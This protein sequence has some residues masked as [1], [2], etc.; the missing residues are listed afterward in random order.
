MRYGCSVSAVTIESGLPRTPVRL[1]EIRD[2]AVPMIATHGVR[3]LTHRGVDRA[4]HV[5]LG[6]TSHY[7]PTRNAL[8][9]LV[10]DELIV[11][12]ARSARALRRDIAGAGSVDELA[13]AVVQV[14]DRLGSFEDDL[15]ARY[16]LLSDAESGSLRL[17]L[18]T[19]SATRADSIAA[20]ESV[21]PS[22]GF[23]DAAN[24]SRNLVDLCDGLIWLRTTCGIDAGVRSI[25]TS[26]LHGA[27]PV[28]PS[29]TDVPR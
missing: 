12:A 27:A 25:V 29:R 6:T 10:V 5:P 28:A 11:R 22:L 1:Q 2:A 23:P 18:G 17:Q 21:L 26:F 7:A 24:V 3:A 4:A 16:A 14:V 13:D 20:L 15:R 9:E 8:I 19:Q